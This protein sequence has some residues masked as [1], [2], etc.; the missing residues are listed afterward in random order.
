[1]KIYVLCFVIADRYCFV[2]LLFLGVETVADHMVIPTKSRC[3]G[4]ELL[5]QIN[6]AVSI[7]MD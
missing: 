4:I 1:M 7:Y 3:A 6:V 5:K 2:V